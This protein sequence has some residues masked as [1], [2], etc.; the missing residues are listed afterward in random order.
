MP[1][2]AASGGSGAGGGGVSAAGGSPGVGASPAGICPSS[3]FVTSAPFEFEDSASRRWLRRRPALRAGAGEAAESYSLLH[4]A[5]P[6]WE[7][8]SV[9]VSGTD[10]L[11][12]LFNA[13]G[14]DSLQHIY[15][16][17]PVKTAYEVAL[18]GHIIQPLGIKQDGGGKMYI[19]ITA[20]RFGIRTI[21]FKDVIK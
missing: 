21:K 2:A 20:S 9:T 8:S 16:G 17:F 10:L 1:C 5:N 3:G 12:R 13:E 15:P 11:V 19:P 14:K 7:V 6:G 18:D 4:L